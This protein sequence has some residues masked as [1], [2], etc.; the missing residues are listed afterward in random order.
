ME[1][2]EGEREQREVLIRYPLFSC[3]VDLMSSLTYVRFIVQGYADWLK[4]VQQ[5]KAAVVVQKYVRRW[6]ARRHVAMMRK[7]VKKKLQREGDT[8]V[9]VMLR[10]ASSALEIQRI[11][12]GYQCRKRLHDARARQE[13]AALIQRNWRV[14]SEWRKNTFLRL[15]TG[16]RDRAVVTVRPDYPIILSLTL[17]FYLTCELPL[18]PCSDVCIHIITDPMLLAVL[19]IPP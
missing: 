14:T 1:A 18:C 12:R 13:G 6:L 19:C 11:I 10:R 5:S 17:Q 4:F 15:V 8:L 16:K 9:R 7:M 3:W 2:L